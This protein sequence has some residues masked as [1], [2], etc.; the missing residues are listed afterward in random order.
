MLLLKGLKPPKTMKLK[1]LALILCAAASS[2]A[3]LLH[4]ELSPA[5]T[6]VAV[7]LSPSNSVPV[8]TNSTG[9]GN[10]VSGGIVFDTDTSL[11]QLAIGYGSAAGFTDLTGVPTLMHIHGPAAVGQN[12]GPIVDLMPYN[13]PAADP[14]KG[15]VILGTFSFPTNEVSSLLG[16]SNY[17]NIHTAL[18]PGG[19]IRG[20]LMPVTIVNQPPSVICPGPVT[21]ECATAAEV[22]VLVTDPEGDALT[23]VWSVNGDVVQT[24]TV[25]ATSPPAAANLT[26]SRVLPLGTNIVSILV[27]DVAT[28]TA[29]C[30]TMVAVVDTTPP[31]IVS[32]SATPNVLWPPNHKMVAISVNADVTDTCGAT[33]WKIIR[34]RSNEAVNGRGD[35]NTAP[36]WVI[37]G[38]HTL[39]LRAERSGTK[40]DRV[41]TITIQAKDESKNLSEPTAITVTVPKSQGNSNANGNGNG[42][43]NANGNGN[44]GGNSNGN[45]NANGNGNG[46]AGNGNGGKPK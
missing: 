8:V 29:S 1:T 5:G 9:S 2:Q 27:T 23:I 35:G 30:A 28:N 6:D 25:A 3:A 46:N 36:D 40:Q 4:F 38:A 7:G 45:G 44:G 15:G 41:Y 34:V 20:Q 10:A 22:T 37:T 16:G 33:T 17:V 12:A 19:E 13:F 14:T 39:K 24:S 21:A 32:A 31:V 11:M 43:G 18:N 26:L 42:N